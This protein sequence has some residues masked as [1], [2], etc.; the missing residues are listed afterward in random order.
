M[1]NQAPSEVATPRRDRIVA[2][3]RP[4]HLEFLNALE[5]YHRARVRLAN[6]VGLAGYGME[7]QQIAG[8]TFRPV[9]GS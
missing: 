7:L 2:D 8:I 4:E 9:L 3:I 5:D 6:A 1:D